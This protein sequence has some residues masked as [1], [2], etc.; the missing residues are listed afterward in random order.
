[1]SEKRKY[2]ST[3]ARIAGNIMSGRTPLGLGDG[4][5]VI[6]AV[7]LARA[8]VAEVER[9]EPQQATPMSPKAW[10]ELG[11]V[12]LASMDLTHCICQPVTGGWRAISPN[13]RLHGNANE[14]AEVSQADKTR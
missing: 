12:N 4:S 13:C 8:I 11:R 5:A 6:W 3:V 14:N 10:E 7:R 2:D 1:M 9:T